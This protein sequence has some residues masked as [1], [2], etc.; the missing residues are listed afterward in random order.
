M[1]REPQELLPLVRQYE[2]KVSEASIPFWMDAP[3]ILDVL[4]YYEQKGLYFESEQ[5]MRL[6]LRL[7][8][9]NDEV[10]VRKAYRL[11]NEGRWD[12]AQEWVRRAPTQEG[13]EVL[14]FR[15][16]YALSQLKFEEAE[17]LFLKGIAHEMGQKFA[18]PD[19]LT[20]KDA[21]SDNRA[22]KDMENS[23]LYLEMSELFMDYGGPLL[24]QKYLAK[25]GSDRADYPRAQ[26]LWAECE[27]QE[28]NAEKAIQRLNTLL[29]E[30]PYYI[31]AWILVAD[32]SNEMKNFEK[33]SEA[34]QFALAI[35]PNNEKALRFK[36]VAALSMERFEEVLEIYAIYHQLYPIDYTM[37]LSAGE[38]LL[39]QNKP[40]EAREVLLHSCQVCPNENPDKQRIL[41]DIALTYLVERNYP[42]AEEIMLGA[43]SLGLSHIE[44]LFALAQLCLAQKLND[45]GLHCLERVLTQEPL[46]S[47]N[48]LRAAKMLAEANLFEPAL[49]LWNV[50][51]S[52]TV[53]GPT[54]AAPYL[55]FA[56]R[57]L[58]RVRDFFFWI[59]Y[60]SYED[61]TLTKQVFANVY[62][63]VLPSDYLARARAEFPQHSF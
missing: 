9:D 40:A 51:L 37:A 33:C 35:D 10:I 4:D 54:S 47:D 22:D 1:K 6:A 61:P 55:A 19:D 23:Y 60:A 3:D 58:H 21:T 42:K 2:Q 18:A 30:D 29:D 52:V 63:G 44:M 26:T 39:H 59:A 7:H 11:K 41:S 20:D 57:R 56:A 16:E 17:Q 32:I 13:I 38:I 15:A 49:S 36:A 46:T 12:E 28:G 48:R 8:P 25:I 5:C 24:A 34:S 50:L 31:E 45:E 53:A 27:F 62:P 43:T 14:F